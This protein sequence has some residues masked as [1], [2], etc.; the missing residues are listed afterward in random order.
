MKYTSFLPHAC[1]LVPTRHSR[2]HLKK[3]SEHPTTDAH[4]HRKS[5]RLGSAECTNHATETTMMLSGEM[6]AKQTS[7]A[8]GEVNPWVSNIIRGRKISKHVRV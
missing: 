2:Q 3:R 5:P 8:K 1:L 7:P 6:T 4:S